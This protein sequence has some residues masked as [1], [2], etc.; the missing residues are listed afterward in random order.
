MK[1]AAHIVLLLCVVLYSLSAPVM[2]GL[3]YLESDAI[4]RAYCVNPDTPSCH[5]RCHMA[6][7]TSKKQ[8]NSDT[9]PLVERTIEK[10][11]LFFTESTAYSSLID[12]AT[13][14]YGTSSSSDLHSGYP[15][16]IY[17]PPA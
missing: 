5:G 12:C 11:L 14:P 1:I 13:L 4:A 16:R 9:P 7:L 8:E 3:Y 2:W 15:Q 6:K 17:H 10:P